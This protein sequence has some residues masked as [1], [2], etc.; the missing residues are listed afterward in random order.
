MICIYQRPVKCVWLKHSLVMAAFICA[1]GIAISVSAADSPI[2][3]TL[4]SPACSDGWVMDDKVKLYNKDNLF[5]RINGEA[6]LYFPYGFEALASA[7][8]V[9]VRNP[10]HS[11]EAD[12]YKMG[13]LLDAFG[14]Y[15]NYRR[16]EDNNV[17]VGA[18]GTIASSLLLFYQGRYFIRLQASGTLNIEKDIFLACANAISRKLPDSA[19]RPRELD[20]FTLPVVVKNSERYIA[21]SLLGYDFLRRG[22]IADVMLN[23][24]QAQVF[25]V[26]ED[27]AIEARK[28]FDYYRSYLKVPD[29]RIQ[30][31]KGAD[32]INISAADPLYGGVVVFQAGRNVFGVIRVEDFVAAR[33]LMDQMKNKLSD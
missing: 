7:R 29:N 11:V 24:K 14:I 19:V 6:E 28:V 3:K 8:Y 17:K 31:A 5:D 21:R 30:S 27:S 23:G 32:Y 4:P 25:V 1:F 33:Q 2:E 22:I 9:S 10:Q 18:E 26:R 12:V 20:A 15:A 13:S 16:A